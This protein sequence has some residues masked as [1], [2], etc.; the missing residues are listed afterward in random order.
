MTYTLIDNDSD[1]RY[2]AV[3]GNKYTYIKISGKSA[4]NQEIYDEWDDGIYEIIDG[5]RFYY[6]DG[7]E[8]EFNNVKKGDIVAMQIP[9]GLSLKNRSQTIDYVIL[10]DRISGRVTGI[11]QDGFSVD[12]KEYKTGVFIES[13]RGAGKVRYWALQKASYYT[14]R[15][16]NAW[17]MF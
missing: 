4:E 17:R 12:G 6:A 9:S 3:Y 2:E 5:D 8:T 16:M 1:G 7:I 15:F 11:T 13:S 10:T 14:K